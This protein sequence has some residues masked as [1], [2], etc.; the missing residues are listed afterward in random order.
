M[1]SGTAPGPAVNGALIG[2]LA[3]TG[4]VPFVAAGTASSTVNINVGGL[5]MQTSF[6][7]TNTDTFTLIQNGFNGSIL[8]TNV[9][10]GGGETFLLGGNNFCTITSTGDLAFNA[11]GPVTLLADQIDRIA[12][13]GVDRWKWNHNGWRRQ[14]FTLRLCQRRSG[15]YHNDDRRPDCPGIRNSQSLRQ[16]PYLAVRQREFNRQR[17]HRRFYHG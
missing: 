10:V 2:A 4:T 12:R 14:H 9:T 1:S 5:Q 6:G 7:G 17:S 15:F 13:N 3:Y 16:C 11:T 8:P